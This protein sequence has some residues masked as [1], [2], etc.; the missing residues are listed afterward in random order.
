M[1]GLEEDDAKDVNEGRMLH[2]ER[3]EKGWR[4]KGGHTEGGIAQL[5][6]HCC[7][8]QLSDQCVMACAVQCSAA[9]GADRDDYSLS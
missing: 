9:A 7:L 8:L 2:R 1:L 5:N 6:K 4:D 3:G